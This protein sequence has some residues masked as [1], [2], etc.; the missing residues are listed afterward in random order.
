ML[1]KKLYKWYNNTWRKIKKRNLKKAFCK[2]KEKM[3][4]VKLTNVC[5]SYDDEINAVN[6]L[7]LEINQGEYI[8]VLG[9][10]GSG[11]STVAKLINGLITAQSGSVEVFG[12]NAANKSD[13]FEIRKSVG[14]VFQNPDN[15]MVATIVEDD[16]AFG[17]ENIGVSREQIA[18]R[19]EFAL[20]ATGTL[21]FRNRPSS[22]LSGGQKQRVAIAGVLAINPKILILDEATSMLDPVGREEVIGVIKKLNKE[23]GL[24]VIC[25]THYMEEALDAD[26]VI[27][28]DGGKVV[29]SGTPEQI[30]A[31]EKRI[32]ECGLSLPRAA[33]IYNRLKERGVDLGDQQVYTVKELA[34][35]LCELFAKI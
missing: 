34:D 2:K 22:E 12:L 8:V 26:R 27:V 3:S 9:R 13:L 25:V 18:Q 21:S 31:C 33:Y 32:E 24:T 29:M 16:I 1:V 23:N 10:N 30:F 7:S 15:Q 35:R 14:M 5:F 20:N 11:K 6:N 17:P 4:A 19:I 28:M